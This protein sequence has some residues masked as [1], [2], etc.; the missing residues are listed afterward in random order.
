MRTARTLFAS[1]AITAVFAV[2]APTAM[3]SPAAEVVT[4]VSATSAHH[5]DH[6]R[7]CHHWYGRHH[8]MC[9]HHHH[10][11]HYRPVGGTHT[12]G[13]ARVDVGR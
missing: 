1:A 13:G 7:S 8:H 4:T 5:D 10:R 3:A 6:G 9:R 11:H 12:R 2:G